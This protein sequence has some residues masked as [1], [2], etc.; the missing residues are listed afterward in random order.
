MLY[1]AIKALLSG[2]IIAIV[3][4]VARKSPGLGAL[5]VSLP[6]LSILAMIWLWRE[7]RDPVRLADHAGATFWYVI[8]SLPMFLLLPMLLKRGV[9]FWP[10]LAAGCLL[11]MVLYAVTIWLATR[12]GVRL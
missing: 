4:E 7:T 12:A 2:V 1:L 10:A 3:S 5:I 8:P 6:L 11:T 9:G